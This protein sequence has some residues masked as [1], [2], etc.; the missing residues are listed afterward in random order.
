MHL[1]DRVVRSTIVLAFVLAVTSCEMRDESGLAESDQ[2]TLPVSS[3]E[4]TWRPVQ[5]M[6]T[7]GDSTVTQDEEPTLYIFTPTHFAV[8]GTV[9]GPR[10]LYHTLDP[11]DEEKLSA[12]NSFWGNM[13][14][15]EVAGDSLTMH[16]VFARNPN[17]MAGGYRVS[18]FR[19]AG[20]TLWLA[21]K[22]TDGHFRLGEEV[23][24]DPR[25]F[26]ETETR[27]VRVR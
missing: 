17:Y 4:G 7:R 11:T 21:T 15:Y 8:M 6:V 5:A 25:P 3:L 13:G 23:V 9:G 22:S 16:I 24:P 19:V 20:D 26:S 12:F 14:T 1:G 18:R 2:S 27:L 10:T